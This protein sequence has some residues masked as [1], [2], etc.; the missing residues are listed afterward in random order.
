MGKEILSVHEG[1]VAIG[2]AKAKNP[3]LGEAVREGQAPHVFIVHRKGLEQ[4][5][6][7]VPR[8]EKAREKWYQKMNGQN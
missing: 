2:M 5:C 4:H 6:R 7:V 3:W 8:G 1:A